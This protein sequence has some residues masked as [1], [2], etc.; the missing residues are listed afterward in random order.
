[1]KI[2]MCLQYKEQ[3]KENRGAVGSFKVEVR[4]EGC[5]NPTQVWSSRLYGVHPSLSARIRHCGFQCSRAVQRVEKHLD[6]NS[7][8]IALG[9]FVS[10]SK[11]IHSVHARPALPALLVFQGERENV[12]FFLNVKCSSFYKLASHSVFNYCNPKK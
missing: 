1:M 9:S 3:G 2:A 5:L 10:L 8:V 7:E 6:R 4:K 11:M 12:D